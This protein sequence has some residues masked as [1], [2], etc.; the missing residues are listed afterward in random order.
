[1]LGTAIARWTGADESE[2][3]TA[4]GFLTVRVKGGSAW[5]LIDRWSEVC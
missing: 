4:A 3:A 2:R 5:E 1:M